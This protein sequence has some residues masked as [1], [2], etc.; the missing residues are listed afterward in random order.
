MVDAGQ[1]DYELFDILNRG[2]R[3]AVTGIPKDKLISDIG[4][5]LKNSIKSEVDKIRSA[6]KVQ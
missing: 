4:H 2:K 6:I 5:D 3:A 1:K